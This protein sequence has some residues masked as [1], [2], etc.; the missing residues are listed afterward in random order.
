MR[1]P[2]DPIDVRVVERSLRGAITI[3][4]PSDE[5]AIQRTRIRGD[6][7]RQG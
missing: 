4:A 2:V 3:E 1:Q 6:Y 7:L 5:L